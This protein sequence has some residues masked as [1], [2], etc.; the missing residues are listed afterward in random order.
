MSKETIEETLKIYEGLL[1][2]FFSGEQSKE[3]SD[4][5]LKAIKEMQSAFIK[6]GFMDNFDLEISTDY[7]QWRNAKLK[8][9][10]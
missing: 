7:F 6:N 10:I 4:N 3:Q 1:S 2:R 9:A 8:E 5:T